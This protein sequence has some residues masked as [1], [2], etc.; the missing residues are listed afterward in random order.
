MDS[1]IHYVRLAKVYAAGDR[2]DDAIEAYKKAIELTPGNGQVYR[3]LAQL[4][5]RKDDL[6]AAEKT[7]EEAIQYTG[8]EWERRN[9]E[10]Q[11]MGIYRHQGKL[12]EML[13]RAEDEGTLTLEMQRERAQRYRNEGELEKAVEAYKKAL[14]MTAQSWERNGIFTE[15][16]QVYVQLDENDLAVE[17]YETLSRSGSTGMSIHHSPSGVK[18]AFGGDEARETLINAYKNQGKLEQLKTLFEG[19]LEKEVDN[20]AILE[21]VAEIY[22][23]ANDHEQA[24]K[25]YQA[26]CKAQPGN[27]RSF[28]RCCYPQ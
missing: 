14:D 26:L 16:V 5:L 10:Q 24:A 21:M 28:L 8:Q 1:G 25:A 9:I 3:E 2:V 17:V 7:F 11:L 18:V 15:L 20:P 23:N 12:E 4:Y 19:R 6:E 13:K 22:R 27:V